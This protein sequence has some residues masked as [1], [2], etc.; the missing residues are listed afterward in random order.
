MLRSSHAAR[1]NASCA[2]ASRDDAGLPSPRHSTSGAVSDAANAS[3]SESRRL[4]AGTERQKRKVAIVMI[5]RRT[6]CLAQPIAFSQFLRC[7]AQEDIGGRG[8][9][10]RPILA[11]LLSPG[12]SK[13]ILVAKLRAAFVVGHGRR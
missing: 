1:R 10:W 3:S 2:R 4:S 13:R 5:G 6:L 8:S 12:W 11:F 9:N 7:S